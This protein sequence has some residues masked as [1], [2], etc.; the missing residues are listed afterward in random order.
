MGE[1]PLLLAPG[2]LATATALLQALGLAAF[3]L[4]TVAHPVVGLELCA[5][6]CR[7]VVCRLKTP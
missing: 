6:G 7:L 2:L 3:E 1:E 4:R 5:D